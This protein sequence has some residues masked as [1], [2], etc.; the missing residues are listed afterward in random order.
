MSRANVSQ[1]VGQSVGGEGGGCHFL[2][3]KTLY[4][5][6]ITLTVL[7]VLLAFSLFG[8]KNTCWVWGSNPRPHEG[9]RA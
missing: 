8:K 6:P 4:R 2:A 1:S 9:I 3:E 5:D 7:V